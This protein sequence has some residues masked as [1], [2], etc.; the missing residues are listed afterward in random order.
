MEIRDMNMLQQ[1]KKRLPGHKRSN[2]VGKDT[3]V[4]NIVAY[5]FVFIFA[6]FCLL[7]MY[8]VVV[9]SFTGE[10]TI[11]REGYSFY[12]RD[13]SL[14][15]YKI[16]LRNPVALTRS[17]VLTVM[18]TVI[19]TV[20]A[21]HMAVSTGYVLSRKDFKWRNSFSYFFFFTTLFNSGLVPWYLWSSNVL[22]FNN[23]LHGL[24]LP[25]L[26]SVWNVIIA[27]NY[28]SGISF[29]IIESAKIDGAGDMTIFYKIIL[30]V[31]TPLLATLGLFSALSY[32]NDWYNAMLFMQDTDMY[33][34]QY[35]LQDTLNS[36]DALKRIASQAGRSVKAMP[37]E[38]MKMAMTVIVTAPILILYPLLQKYFI[39][40]LTIGAV[41]G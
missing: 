14:E 22:K 41:K 4:F 15:G 32:W 23:S 39:S 1:S 28:I 13:F 37:M 3:I 33:T 17:F 8:L 36:V 25:L 40:G 30:P 35:Y 9:A 12:I 7:P 11:I 6:F 19:G 10:G 21:V 24:I 18:V 5:A 16:V 27:K 26:F 31:C 34:L 38:S 20:V 2:R 29:E